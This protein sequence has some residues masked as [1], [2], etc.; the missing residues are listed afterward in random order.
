MIPVVIRLM[1][2]LADIILVLSRAVEKGH[3]RRDVYDSIL[4]LIHTGITEAMEE[5]RKGG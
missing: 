5:A 1:K 3:V 2:A 4:T